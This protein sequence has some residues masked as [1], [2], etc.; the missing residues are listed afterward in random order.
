MQSVEAGRRSALERLGKTIRAG[1]DPRSIRP[2]LARA[3]LGGYVTQAE[4]D[5]RAEMEANQGRLFG[6]TEEPREEE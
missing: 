3:I 2:E 4:L 6:Q 5:R 1:K